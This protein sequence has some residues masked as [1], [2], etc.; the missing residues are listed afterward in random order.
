MSLGGLGPPRA[1]G[2]A[3]GPGPAAAPLELEAFAAA[4]DRFAPF[5]PQPA[6][7]V[8]VSGGPDSTALALLAR[9]WARRRGGSARAL[10]VDHRLRAESTAEAAAVAA[11]L[12]GAGIPADILTRRGPP[13]AA[14]VQ[15]A[16]RRDRYALLET[17]CRR[18]GILHL[19]LAHT[20]DDQAETVLLRL[21]AG[22]GPDGLAGMADVRETHAVRLLRPLLAVPKARLTATC[23][24]AGIATVADPS[25]RDPRYA[26]PRLRA[27]A[28]AL[29]REGLTPARAAGTA[30]ACGLARAAADAAVAE[31]LAAAVAIRPEGWL[32]VA[33][34][35]LRD[36]P[37]AT[38]R[39][40]LVR[41]LA[42]VGGGGPAPRVE[43]LARLAGVV[44]A[45]ASGDPGP[46]GRGRTLGGCRLLPRP[47]GAR[48]A[49]CRELA[50]VAPPV[51]LA[52]GETVRWDGRFRVTMSREGPL[53]HMAS[54]GAAG[55]SAGGRSGV[56]IAV[57]R[58]LPALLPADDAAASVE[59]DTRQAP[60]GSVSMRS[61]HVVFAPDVPLAGPAFGIV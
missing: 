30:S 16:A 14:A 31:L 39:A 1:T 33:L 7:A 55:P 21:A 2:T 35:P 28:A 17:A 3:Q 41:C 18:L 46:L 9:D 38:L 11:R 40:A 20:L 56:P 32:E 44:R 57:M 4:M 58:T 49:V 43:R 29:A 25:N 61:V 13:P 22:S 19:L 53:P 42:T 52:P 50:A 5:E 12:D 45:A 34:A 51:A 24:A 15:A 36:V 54:I 47:G 59:I 6:L 27:G 10:I 48:L 37:E 8:A 26:R 60:A 23:R